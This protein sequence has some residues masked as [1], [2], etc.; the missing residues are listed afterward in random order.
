MRRNLFLLLRLT[1]IPFFLREYVQRKRVTILCYH[2]MDPQLAELHIRVLKR[3]YN[4]IP[5]SAY[6]DARRGH[7]STVIPPKALA[8]TFDDGHKGNYWLLPVFRQHQVPATIF[9]CSGI[10]GTHRHYW[11]KACPNIASVYALKP[12]DND[13]RLWR[14]SEFGFH[15][16][17]EYVERQSLSREEIEELRVTMDLQAHSRYHPIL[18]RCTDEQS[19]EEIAGSKMEL[20]KT[21]G[22]SIYAFA[23]PN[24]DYSPRET[25]WA[26][27][28]GYA[29]ALTIDGGYNTL[30]TD[31]FRLRRLRVDDKA[32]L[33]ELIVKA[34]GLWSFFE[35]ILMRGKSIR[36]HVLS[37][38]MSRKL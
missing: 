16:N 18:P 6:I 9:L 38:V 27:K 17:R 5:L 21:F 29:C 8:I 31:M 13:E 14:L 2:D 24:G 35:R 12:L 37:A 22:L 7:A 10:V 15:E 25:V 33:N 36:T 26:K 20:E 4:I 23:Y 34:S 28:A 32:D 30:D 3:L 19:W 1:G 11:W